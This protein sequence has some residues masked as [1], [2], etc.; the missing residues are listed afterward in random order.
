MAKGLDGEGL[1]YLWTKIKSFVSN[2]CSNA[3]SN[4]I[5]SAKSYT[6]TK[7]I[8]YQRQRML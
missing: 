3:I 4:A 8:V 2:S 6:D 5:S 1:E 7:L